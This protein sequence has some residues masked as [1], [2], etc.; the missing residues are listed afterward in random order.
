MQELDKFE[1]VATAIDQEINETENPQAAA[2]AQA[3]AILPPLQEEIA[4]ML[5]LLAN[6]GSMLVPT[7]NQHFN[8]AANMQIAKAIEQLSEKY[9]YDVRANLLI[10]DSP[11]ML[12]LGL[13][14]AIG[15]PARGVYVDIKAMKAA[16][17]DKPA[18]D[19]PAATDSDPVGSGLNAVVTGA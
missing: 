18:A 2:E 4:D 3:V 13:A 15:I 12:W 8:H 1:G 5:D 14:F 9:G 19:Q 17:A 11:A 10:N 16:A 7:F 6:A